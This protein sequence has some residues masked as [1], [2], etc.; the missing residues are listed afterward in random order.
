MTGCYSQEKKVLEREERRRQEN[1]SR[2]FDDDETWYMCHTCIAANFEVP[3][4]GGPAIKDSPDQHWRAAH[5]SVDRH[6]DP[7]SSSP[8]QTS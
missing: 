4:E 2:N 5:C 1:Y 6:P 3:Q 7:F 8:T